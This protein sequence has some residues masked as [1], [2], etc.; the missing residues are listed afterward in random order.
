MEF[1]HF[2]VRNPLKQFS[3]MCMPPNPPSK[4]KGLFYEEPRPTCTFNKRCGQVEISFC[5]ED[6]M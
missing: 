5:N 1:G 3:Q 4:I 6:F 2:R